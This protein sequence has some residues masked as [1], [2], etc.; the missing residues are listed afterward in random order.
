MANNIIRVGVKFGC[1]LKDCP[2]T[3]TITSVSDTEVQF[4]RKGVSGI[5]MMPIE[6]FCEIGIVLPDPK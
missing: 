3:M 2:Q 4:S 5:F 6:K 1:I